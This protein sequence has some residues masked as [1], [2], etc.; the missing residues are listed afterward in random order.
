MPAGIR[1]QTGVTAPKRQVEQSAR[2]GGCDFEL[3]YEQQHTSSAR[4]VRATSSILAITL[5]GKGVSVRK[6]EVTRRRAEERKPR[7]NHRR[8]KGEKAHTKRMGT[9]AD[10]YMIAP[11]VR[12]PDQIVRELEQG[13]LPKVSRGNSPR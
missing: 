11:F 7:L 3:F 1:N 2:R 8:S 10:V 4:E 12:T 6:A 13:C 5:D 9:L